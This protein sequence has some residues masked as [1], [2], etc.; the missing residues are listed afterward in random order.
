M[1][2]RIQFITLCAALTCVSACSTIGDVATF[3]VQAVYKTGELAGK[4]IYYTGRG[5]G[6]AVYNTGRITGKGVYYTGRG[7]YNTVKVPVKITNSALNT[8][9]QF[10][11]VTTKVV[12]LSGKVANISRTMQRSEVDGYIAQAKGATNV[13]GILVDVAKRF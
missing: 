2:T 9:I 12:D 13:L 6:S 11:T 1:H 5:A 7:V 8:S 4:G 3:P 10:L